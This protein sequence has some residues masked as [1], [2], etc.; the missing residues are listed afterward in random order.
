[1]AR[2]VKEETGVDVHRVQYLCSQPWPAARGSFGQLMIGC[3]AEAESEDFE[4]DGVELSGGKWFTRDELAAALRGEG[5][6]FFVPPP[7]AIAHH[8]V[9]AF[10]EGW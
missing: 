7:F 3:I 4:I 5:K 9:K 6:G 1:M 10:V 2:E 8:L